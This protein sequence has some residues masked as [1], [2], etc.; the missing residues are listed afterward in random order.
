MTYG[1]IDYSNR[2]AVWA[3]VWYDGRSEHEIGQYDTYEEAAARLQQAIQ[4]R[5]R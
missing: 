2:R 1:R 4:S 5:K 3:V